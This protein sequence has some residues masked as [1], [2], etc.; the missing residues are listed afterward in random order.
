MSGADADR[1]ADVNR[2]L[3]AGVAVYNAG[4][5]HAAHDAWEEPWLELD[6]GPEKDFLQGLIQFTAAVHHA[7]EGNPAGATGL[8]AS[9]REYLDGLGAAF[10]GVALDPVREYLRDL[11]AD[12][13]VVE[14]R[15]PVRLEIG[16]RT[17]S[18]A[19]LDFE[20]SVVAARILAEE[21]GFDPELIERAARYGR[22]D[23]D[24]GRATSPFVS[25]V[26]DFAQGRNRALVYR[27][28]SEHA[29]RREHEEGDVE[30]LFG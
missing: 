13:A 17:V 8:A 29:A 3:R 16:G 4:E 24:A 28:L 14:R 25:L 6:A 10:R 2:H 18:V 21:H 1:G 12:P 27:R 19:D 26:M 30:G 23:L 11:E 9:A 15:P 5:Y 20:E 7:V 22:A